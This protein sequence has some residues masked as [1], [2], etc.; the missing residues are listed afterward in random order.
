[1]TAL[2]PADWRFSDAAAAR[3][4]AAGAIVFGHRNGPI[5]GVSA[6]G[7]MADTHRV[8]EGQ[9]CNFSP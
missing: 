9:L 7:V 1:M 5:D 2:G 4:I 8:T 3:W 6:R